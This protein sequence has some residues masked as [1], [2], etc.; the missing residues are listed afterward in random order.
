M[1][2]FCFALRTGFCDKIYN[3]I[4]EIASFKP[5]D[6]GMPVYFYDNYDID[7]KAGYGGQIGTGARTSTSISMTPEIDEIVSK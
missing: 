1:S 2:N 6:N 7:M 4:T 5:G 3:W